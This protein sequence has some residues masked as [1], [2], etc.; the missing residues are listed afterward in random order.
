VWQFFDAMKSFARDGEPDKFLCA[1]GLVSH[2]V[3]DACQPLH[4]SVLADGYA[5]IE[6]EVVHTR[7]ETGEEYTEKSH[8]GAGVHSTYETKMVDRHAKDLVAG[9]EQAIGQQV[10]ALPQIRSGKD[11][12]TAI[13]NLMNRSA[14]LIPP[15]SLVDSFV[16]LG[17]KTTVGVQDKLWEEFGEKTIAL[18]TDG[19]RVLARIWEGAWI[20][21]NG[22]AIP[23]DELG[24]IDP[25]ALNEYCR[26]ITF[27][28]SVDLDH[29]E[30]LLS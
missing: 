4:G 20:E 16:E 22:Q 21:G 2:Y 12:A 10:P 13:L 7:Q 8:L 9:I 24:P 26:D 17:G 3:G 29:I 6:T 27:V 15:K 25:D 14:H 28:E 19:A 5:D 18:M 11:A 30:P 1:A 23:E